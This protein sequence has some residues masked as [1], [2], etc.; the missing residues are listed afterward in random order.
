MLTKEFLL[1]DLYQTM[2]LQE[3]LLLQL[4][5]AMC[6]ASVS[7]SVV[8]RSLSALVTIPPTSYPWNYQIVDGV[9]PDAALTAT[10]SNSIEENGY[11]SLCQCSCVGLEG[12][13]GIASCYCDVTLATPIPA[14]PTSSCDLGMQWNPSDL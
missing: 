4:V 9:Q 5:V 10:F 11:A 8:S 13:H 3:L 2:A 7:E 1:N 14:T 12:E 6:S